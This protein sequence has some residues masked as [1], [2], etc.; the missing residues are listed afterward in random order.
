MRK[1]IRAHSPVIAKLIKEGKIGI[2]GGMQD[3]S[4][5]KVTFFDNESVM[6]K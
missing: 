2:I 6:P 3:L 4:T 5:G 1:Q